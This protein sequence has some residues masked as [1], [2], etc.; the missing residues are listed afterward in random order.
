MTRLVIVLA[1]LTLTIL[2]AW[3]PLIL[4]DYQLRKIRDDMCTQKSGGVSSFSV[5]VLQGKHNYL[6]FYGCDE[7]GKPYR[8]LARTNSEERPN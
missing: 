7:N 3:T 2:L 5:L 6:S 4:V 1:V 8:M